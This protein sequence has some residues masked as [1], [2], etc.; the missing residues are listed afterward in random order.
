MADKSAAQSS[1]DVLEDSAAQSSVDVAGSSSD[2][3]SESETEHDPA[4]EQGI[5]ERISKFGSKLL[6]REDEETV[7]LSSAERVIGQDPKSASDNVDEEP[8]EVSDSGK[9]SSAPSDTVDAPKVDEA[10]LRKALLR[11]FRQPEQRQRSNDQGKKSKSPISFW[12]DGCGGA[13]LRQSF[14]SYQ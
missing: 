9:A 10:G 1:V 3:I 14:Q 11:A 13:S 7:Q 6:G 2:T 8:A 4:A 12:A 5:F